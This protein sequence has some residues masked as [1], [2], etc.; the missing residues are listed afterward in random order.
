MRALM[1]LS[2]LASAC[3]PIDSPQEPIKA[4]I[5]A[6]SGQEGYRFRDVEFST[7]RSIGPV[8]GDFALVKGSAILN[9]NSDI[10]EVIASSDPAA[11]YSDR[12]H[13]LSID[14]TLKD[15]VVYPRDF[16]SMA[17]LAIYYNFERTFKFWQEYNNL[18]IDDFGFTT[19]YNNPILKADTGNTSTEIETKVNAAFL[20]GVRDLWF[21]KKSKL[22]LVPIKMNF[23]IMAHEFFHSLFDLLVAQKDVDFYNG[24]SSA[25]FTLSAINEGMAD[26]FA[27]LVTERKAELGESL[28]IMASS[29]V[30][31]VSWFESNYRFACG[32]S[33]YCLGSVLNSA[34]YEA[35]ETIGMK[36]VGRYVLDA[37]PDLRELWLANREVSF[38]IDQFLNLIIA[39]ASVGDQVILCQ[40]LT[41]W[42]NSSAGLLTCTAS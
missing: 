21:L 13:G 39:K 18:S 3:G 40:S 42:F 41:K 36:E 22:A 6:S 10:N 17:A 30:P 11:I 26:F 9:L 5:L 15:G 24:S 32:S 35:G 7:L 16:T 4:R 20:T 1:T 37:L 31:P 19:I 27:I 29:R 38:T 25:S 14:Y 28:A 2:L 12:G 33:Y 8:Q 23:A 34:L